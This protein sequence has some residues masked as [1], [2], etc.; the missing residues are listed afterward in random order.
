MAR[1]A[2]LEDIEALESQPLESHN[3]PSST[4]EAIKRTASSYPNYT[5]LDFFLQAADYK[6]SVHVTYKEFLEKIHQA[7]NL[8]HSL[9][10]RP[11]DCVSYILPNLPQTY[12]TLFGGEAAGIAGPINPL[13]EPHVLA[14]IMKASETKVLVTITPFPN[15]DIWEKVYQIADDVPTLETI[16]Q[17]DIA[18]YLGGI[19]KLAVNL[20]RLGKNKKD[21]RA[22]VLEFDKEMARQPTDRLVS[23]RQIEPDEIASYFHTG[24]TTGTPKLAMHTH[25]NEVFDGWTVS[26]VIDTQ[27][28]D[29]TLLGLPLFHNYG[30]I[31]IGVHSFLSGAGIVMGTPSGYRGEEFIPNFWKILEHFDV[32][33]FGAVP[34]LYTSL[35]NVPVDADISK[36]ELTTCGAAPLAVELAKQ[37]QKHAGIK[38][39]EGYGLTEGTSVNAI[40]PPAGEA[41]IGSIGLR[42]PYQE[43]GIAK[44]EDGHFIGLA[45]PEEAGIVV[46]RGPNVFPGYKEEFHNT[47]VFLDA[48]DGQGPWLNTGDMG[49][50]DEDG[51]FWLTGRKKELIIRGGHNIDPKQIEEPLHEHPAVALC[52]SIGRPDARVGEMP[53]AYV[54][55]KDGATAT[56]DELLTFARENIGERAAVP[57]RIYIV[58]EIPLTAVGKIFKPALTREQIKEVFENTMNALDG[59]VSSEC[60]VTGDKRLGNVAAITVQAEAGADKEAVEQAI[61]QALGS[62]TVNY[63]LTVS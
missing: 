2:T 56:E 17:I 15:T 43:M 30:A 32:T 58:P 41:K 59:V 55:L 51:Y 50:M 42:L 52:A 57:K 14:D 10:I 61:R 29:K 26:R 31:A 46:I 16:L 63:Q 21:L 1:P 48:E 9:G 47:G 24:G 33:I 62:Y 23:G 35:L 12:Y 8:F 49:R 44:F 53:V 19:K 11:G 36:V 27:P 25:R 18:G 45:N 28:G 13:L 6:N 22:R 38:I 60:V 40:N 5:A 7:A 3:L 20:M 34:T 39:L 4:Y 54:Q 37:F